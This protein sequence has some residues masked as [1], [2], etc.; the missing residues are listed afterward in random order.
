METV[1]SLSGTL[2]THCVEPSYHE[3]YWGAVMRNFWPLMSMVPLIKPACAEEVRVKFASTDFAA[4]NFAAALLR[5]S[6]AETDATAE[7]A[8]QRKRDNMSES[9]VFIGE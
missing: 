3:T 9:F 5:T 8:M 7:K 2:R 1:T 6:A 4:R